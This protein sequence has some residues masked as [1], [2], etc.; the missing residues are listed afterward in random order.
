MNDSFHPHYYLAECKPLGSFISLFSL[1]AMFGKYIDLEPL[2][3]KRLLEYGEVDIKHE[4]ALQL[5]QDI[6]AGLVEPPSEEPWQLP[7]PSPITYAGHALKLR[8]RANA[9]IKTGPIVRM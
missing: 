3:T 8:E 1:K 9:P 7:E 5:Q 4:R 2:R 6:E